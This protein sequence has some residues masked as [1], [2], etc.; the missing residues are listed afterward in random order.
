[1]V[2]KDKLVNMVGKNV[3]SETSAVS[4]APRVKPELT[5]PTTYKHDSLTSFS[6][7]F[8]VC[9]LFYLYCSVFIVL[10][11]LRDKDEFPAFFTSHIDWMVKSFFH[12]KV[13]TC[14]VHLIRHVIVFIMLLNQLN[15]VFVTNCS[16]RLIT[17][18]EHPNMQP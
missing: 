1:M 4:V 8:S 17:T 13:C 10:Y 2:K 3:R 5:L 16:V 7:S 14:L 6:P 15:Q 18:A 12:L 9:I 11:V